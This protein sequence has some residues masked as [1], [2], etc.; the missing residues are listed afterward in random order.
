[1][2]RVP[3]GCVPIAVEFTAWANSLVT[4]VH[5]ERALYIFGPEDGSLPSKMMDRCKMTIKIPTT[6]CLNLAAAVNVVLYD[7]VAKQ[8]RASGITPGL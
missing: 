4:F 7:R 8:M 1:M 2:E 3:H 5:P 6:Y